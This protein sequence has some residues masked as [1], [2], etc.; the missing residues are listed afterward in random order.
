MDILQT[1]DVNSWARVAIDNVC[2]ADLPM[3]IMLANGM[4]HYHQL[5]KATMDHIELRVTA[6]DRR[7]LQNTC[8]AIVQSAMEWLDT[9]LARAEMEDVVYLG[10]CNHLAHFWNELEKIELVLDDPQ[11]SSTQRRAAR[12][13]RREIFKASLELHVF[14][15]CYLLSRPT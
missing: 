9:S 7:T 2:D 14:L 11:A 13:S 3:Q 10:C 1:S 15:P 5:I 4:I 12:R 6:M 8:Q